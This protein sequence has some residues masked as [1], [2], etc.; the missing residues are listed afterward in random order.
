MRRLFWLVALLLIAALG[1][2]PAQAALISIVSMHYSATHPVP[3]LH[4]EGDTVPGDL[5]TLEEMYNTFVKCRISCSGPDGMPTAVL[6]M[7]GNG[8]SYSEGLA[9]ADFLRANH[10]A[11]VVERGAVCYSA[12]AFAFLGGSAYSSQDGVGAYIDRVVEPGSTVGFHAPY[13]NEDAFRAALEERGAMAA[14]G[15]T[16]DALSLMVKELV[17]WNVDPEVIFK[18]VGMGPDQTYDLKTA[19]DLYL[20]RVN[21]PPTPSKGWIT[22]LPAAIKNVCM[23]LIAIDERGDPADT[24]WRFQSEFTE[25]IGVAEYAGPI[26]GFTLGDRPLDIGSCSAPDETLASD[27]EYE[28]SLY[29][30]PG[31]DGFNAAS[32][33]FFNRQKNWSSAGQGRVPTKRIMAKGALNSY[34][35][36][37]DVD[38]DELDLPA[39]NDIDANRFNLLLPPLMATIPSDLVIDATDTGSR[40]SHWGNVYVFERVGPRDLFESALAAGKYGRQYATN[41]ST[42]TSFSRSGVFADTGVSF[43]WFGLLSGGESTVVEAIV[44]PEYEG[45]SPSMEETEF[46]LR[47]E[48]DLSFAGMSLTC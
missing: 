10:I 23:R 30:T 7:N 32:T 15:D 40:I 47:L 48:C 44:L 16:R 25:G 17:K 43:T 45:A 11:T 41:E 8:G 6:T 24:W 39:E 35:L 3:H 29:F 26:S 18:M 31:I 12:C 2:V 34:F 1:T 4:Y 19:E 37:L 33:S 42:E 46:I 13:K 21:L 14:Q 20:A 22:D 38:I 5:A 36:P 27:G 9:M 28:V